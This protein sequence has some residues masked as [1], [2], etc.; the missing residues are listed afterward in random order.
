MKG[1]IF[2]PDLTEDGHLADYCRLCGRLFH[3][4]GATMLNALSSLLFVQDLRTITNI[5]ISLDLNII[6]GLCSPGVS[7]ICLTLK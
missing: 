7:S 1:I 2:E 3:N 5:I 6:A 4:G